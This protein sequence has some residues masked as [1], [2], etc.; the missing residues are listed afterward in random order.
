MINP[1]KEQEIFSAG[2]NSIGGIDEAGRGPL[3]GPVVAA[4][5][6]CPSN[7]DFTQEWLKGI[8]DSKQ[9]SAKKRAA[10]N[11]QILS[12]FPEVGIG[13][14]DHAT[15]DKINI[16]EASFLAMKK[17]IGALRK[18]PDF[19][20]VDGKFIIPNFSIRQQ[21]IISGDK[22]VMIIAAASIVAKVKRDRIMQ[23]MHERFPRY[24][25]NQHKGYGTKQHLAM[26]KEH[27]PCPIHRLSFAPLNKI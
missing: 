6:V 9:L 25:F 17:A 15:I 18:K 16:L 21:A 20:L 24:G 1:G 19:V 12:I 22:L 8:N 3:A 13:L 14:C 4:C 23:E 2:Y 11:D 7:F 10:L 26:I 27:G 5:I